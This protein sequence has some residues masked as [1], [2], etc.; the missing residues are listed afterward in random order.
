MYT[1][2]YYPSYIP[3]N[4]AFSCR[5]LTCQTP[6]VNVS[7]SDQDISIALE[8]PHVKDENAPMDSSKKRKKYIAPT[9]DTYQERLIRNSC[10]VVDCRDPKCDLIHLQEG[11]EEQ[12]AADG[13]ISGG[14]VVDILQGGVND[15]L[16]S[17]ETPQ[18]PKK[19]QRV[20]NENI[21]DAAG[22]EGS[23]GAKKDEKDK[24]IRYHFCV[25]RGCFYSTPLKQNFV[26]H[27]STHTG[28][29]VK[30]E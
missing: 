9:L 6:L 16:L 14:G 17:D 12:K 15:M 19:K 24:V 23:D 3:P 21:T 28:V 18:Q 13:D 1:C 20:P 2:I 10:H 22:G 4:Q 30:K 25:E 26:R 11:E 27:V 29:K 8:L 7:M 5:K